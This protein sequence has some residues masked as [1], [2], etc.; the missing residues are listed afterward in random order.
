MATSPSRTFEFLLQRFNDLT[1]Q[2]FN[3]P[4]RISPHFFPLHEFFLLP[5]YFPSQ[6]TY[7]GKARFSLIRAADQARGKVHDQEVTQCFYFS[8]MKTLIE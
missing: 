4:R 7:V 5:S 2:R 1:I 3:E 6:E 8:F